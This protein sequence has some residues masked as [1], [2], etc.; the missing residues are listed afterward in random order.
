[1]EVVPFALSP[2]RDAL[3]T[4]G[5]ILLKTDE[6]LEPEFRVLI[7]ASGCVLHHTRVENA[8][9]VSPET[10][11]AMAAHIPAAAGLLPSTAGFDVIAYGCTSG[12]LVIGEERVGDLVR[13][14]HPGVA[15]T[16]PLTAVKAR[17]S[18]LG[19]RRIGVLTPYVEAVSA[20]LCDHLAAAGFEIAALVSFD[21]AEDRSVVRIAPGSILDAV[22]RIAGTAPCDAIF[23]SCTN[24]PTLAIAAEAE[25]RTGVPLVSSNGALAWHMLSLAGGR[26]A[27]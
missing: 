9:D 16:N 17:L 1:M 8:A 18:A 2:E 10:L 23:A 26:N 4:L 6:T 24:L 11:A 25:R 21:V 3:L 5:V 13:S 15:V 14:V 19:V 27:A 12:S 22:E 7:P 20:P